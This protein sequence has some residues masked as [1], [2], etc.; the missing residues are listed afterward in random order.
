MA[1][2]ETNRGVSATAIAYVE[3][4]NLPALKRECIIRGLEFEKVCGSIP[5]LQ[6]WF[7]H[8]YNN[9]I[10]NGLLEKYDQWST[11]LLR[12]RGVDEALLAPEFRLGA[13]ILKNAEGGEYRSKGTR[14]RIPKMR[15]K[16]ARTEDKLFTGTKKALTF[17]LQKKGLSKAEVIEKVMAKFPDAKEKSIGIWYNKCKRLHAK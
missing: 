9:P 12:S 17:E 14:S 10:N 6:T 11:L 8:N 5:Q 3:K 13:F 4:L 16:K 1:R 15:E 7:L 2:N